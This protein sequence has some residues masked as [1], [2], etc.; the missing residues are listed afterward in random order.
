MNGVKLTLIYNST[1]RQYPTNIR[2]KKTDSTISSTYRATRNTNELATV[3][4]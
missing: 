1:Y 2:K 4:I 3:Q